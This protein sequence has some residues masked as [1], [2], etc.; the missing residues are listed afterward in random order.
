MGDIETAAIN[1]TIIYRLFP[2]PK[3]RHYGIKEEKSPR[4]KAV[5]YFEVRRKASAVAGE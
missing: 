2:S 4:P 1:L 5:W 3:A